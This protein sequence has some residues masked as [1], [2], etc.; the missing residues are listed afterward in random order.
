MNLIQRLMPL[1]IALTLLTRLPVYRL[2]PASLKSQPWTQQQ[3][4]ESVLWYPVVGVIIGLILAAVFIL[5]QGVEP[6]LL[7]AIILT[8]WVG[9]TGALHLDGF[10]DSV[11]A[12]YAAHRLLPVSDKTAD[13]SSEKIQEQKN[14]V[15]AIFKDPRSGSMA[16]VALCLLLLLKFTALVV[17]ITQ[18]PSSIVMLLIAALVFSRAS[19]IVL[20]QFTPYIGQGMGSGL[21]ACLSESRLLFLLFVIALL[22]FWYLPVMHCVVLFIV[23]AMLLYYWRRFWFRAIGGIVGDC[24]GALIEMAEVAVLLVFCLIPLTV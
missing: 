6:L 4:G 21:K 7:A 20:L 15:L 23:L 1:V 12:A 3:Q 19:S 17:L 5:L 8:V 16:V 24:I 22:S 10:A 14:K 18:Q 2:L 13:D 9:V 11:D